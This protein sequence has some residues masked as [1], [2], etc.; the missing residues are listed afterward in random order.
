MLLPP[1]VVDGVSYVGKNHL[2]LL[3]LSPPLFALRLLTL[4]TLWTACPPPPVSYYY[5][6]P[7]MS[8]IF[9]TAVHG[10]NVGAAYVFAFLYILGI[11]GLFY[12]ILRQQRQIIF[13]VLLESGI[14]FFESEFEPSEPS[15]LAA[16][17]LFSFLQSWPPP[18]L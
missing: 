18:S 13:S 9:T 1:V 5:V 3:L 12:A 15:T 2:F 17:P 14:Y 16:L 6:D 4:W 11:P 10:A 7:D 8:L